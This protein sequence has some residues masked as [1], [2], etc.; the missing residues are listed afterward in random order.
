M[1]II[2]KPGFYEDKMAFAVSLWLSRHMKKPT[3]TE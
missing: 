3:L 1:F 2:M